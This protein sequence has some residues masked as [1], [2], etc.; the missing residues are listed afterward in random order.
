MEN[1]NKK[2]APSK[3]ENAGTIY[4]RDTTLLRLFLT[5]QASSGAD[6]PQRYNGRTR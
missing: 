5:E 1:T 4:D 3:P 2:P 6:T